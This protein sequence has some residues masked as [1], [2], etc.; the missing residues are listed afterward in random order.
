[1]ADA[2]MFCNPIYGLPPFVQDMVRTHNPVMP[3]DEESFSP[4]AQAI[5]TELGRNI[6]R[7][8]GTT[9]Q[10]DMAQRSSGIDQGT[11]SKLEN[12]KQGIS[13]ETLAALCRAFD[14]PAY[15]LF[16]GLPPM[17]ALPSTEAVELAR[18]YDKMSD[19]ERKAVLGLVDS[20][21]PK[22]VKHVHIPVAKKRR[23]K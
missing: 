10:T 17:A 7:L 13:V 2:H 14:K 3:K 5:L 16:G 12:G 21:A 22:P 23:S 15:V 20:L 11:W 1:M 19:R 18:R 8:R 4:A 9:N 6:K